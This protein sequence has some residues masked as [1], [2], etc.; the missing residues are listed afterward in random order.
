[1]FISLKNIQSYKSFYCD[2]FEKKCQGSC[3]FSGNNKN[4]KFMARFSL[5]CWEHPFSLHS[6]RKGY[7]KWA[8]WGPR[9][10]A[11]EM[12]WIQPKSSPR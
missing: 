11:A 12:A 10:E 4:S 7:N 5:F 2:N 1:M 9:H 6:C 8:S 3:Q